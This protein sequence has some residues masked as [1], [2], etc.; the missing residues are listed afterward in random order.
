MSAPAH[1][2]Q[3]VVTPSIATKPPE[4]RAAVTVAK[5]TTRRHRPAT[6]LAKPAATR[7]AQSAAVTPALTVAQSVNGKTAAET[8]GAATPAEAPVAPTGSS[9]A[10]F[11]FGSAAGSAPLLFFFVALVAFALVIPR[12]LRRLRITACLDWTPA[13]LSPLEHPG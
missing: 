10:D 2:A 13:A 4:R 8:A 12:V 1:V 3:T 11:A 7:D 6:F 5:P 9:A